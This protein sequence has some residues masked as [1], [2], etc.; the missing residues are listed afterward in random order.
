MVRLAPFSRVFY[1][2]LTDDIS[3]LMERIGR[4]LRH[5]QARQ[6]RPIT[7]WLALLHKPEETIINLVNSEHP[8]IA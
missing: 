8:H 2:A 1:W 3:L 6:T 5:L 4:Q 7:M